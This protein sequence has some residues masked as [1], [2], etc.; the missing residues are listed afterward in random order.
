V[1]LPRVVTRVLHG[2]NVLLVLT[3]AAGLDHTNIVGW[4]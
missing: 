1:K 3:L 4:N 2:A